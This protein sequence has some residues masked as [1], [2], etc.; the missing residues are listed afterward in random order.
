[1][2]SINV[3]SIVITLGIV[4]WLTLLF[5]GI[6]RQYIRALESLILYLE[7]TK[8]ESQRLELG[9]SFDLRVVLAN[10]GELQRRQAKSAQWNKES[11]IEQQGSIL[12]EQL[13]KSVERVVALVRS[14]R[15]IR[16]PDL[17][18]LSMKISDHLRILDSGACERER[19]L[20]FRR[21]NRQ[22]QHELVE[23]LEQS[24]TQT[25]ALP[26]IGIMGT[27]LGF[28]TSITGLGSAAD[29]GL[30]SNTGFWGL[31]LAMS[32]TLV[33]LSYVVWIK[34]GYEARAIP[35]YIEFEALLQVLEAF[36]ERF[37]NVLARADMSIEPSKS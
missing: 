18:E 21:L 36:V 26:F 25:E 14:R 9:E 29:A 31:I 27:L 4:L 30:F 35:K 28:G 20:T 33:A 3:F 12:G 11:N 37:E 16:Q 32:S 6:R 7:I 10:L 8:V 24:R 34:L 2:T 1:M 23:L 13:F 22:L 5:I 15:T 19:W 17:S